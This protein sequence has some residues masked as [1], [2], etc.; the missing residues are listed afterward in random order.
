VLY[1]LGVVLG[2]GAMAWITHVAL[3]TERAEQ[4]ARRKATQVEKAR[5]ALWRMDS[6]MALFLAPEAAR[7]WSDFES[8]H[9]A[10]RA[11]T[12]TGG[13]GGADVLIPSPMLVADDPLVLLRF[14]IDAGGRFTSPLVPP[15]EFEAAARRVA[16]SPERR[17]VAEVR[18]KEIQGR[19]SLGSVRAAMVRHGAVLLSAGQMKELQDRTGQGGGAGGG[20]TIASPFR[21][22]QGAWTPF[23]DRDRLL[24]ARQVWVGDRELVQGCWLDWSA[25]KEVLMSTIRDILANADLL[26]A[27]PG[28]SPEAAG[29][30]SSLPVRLMPAGP[31]KAAPRLSSP[32]KAALI[33]GWTFTLLGA[34]AGGIVLVRATVQAE[35]RGAFASAVAHELRTP[36]TTFRLYT[37]LLAQGMVPAG[38]QQEMHE[39]LLSEADRL[40]HLVKNVLA[41]ARLESNRGVNLSDLSAGELLDRVGPRLAERARQSGMALERAE[42]EEL[43]GQVLRTDALVVEQIL[44]NLV[45]NACKYAAGAEDR[46]VRLELAREGSTLLLRVRDGGPGI[47]T[48]ERRRLFKPFQK[49]GPK[50]AR[51]APGV[52]LGLALCRRL[53][54]MLGGALDYEAA[55]RGACF[56]L[57]LPVRPG[58]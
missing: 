40:D 38:E 22:F 19:V 2:L 15:A 24:M 32:S 45:D 27:G 12:R 5:L 29:R 51:S 23:W 3:R 9:P 55:E 56:A 31:L 13:A 16:A 58:T 37:E 10:E 34:L 6:T 4:A 50:A 7:P 20:P 57:A 11:L 28:E 43:R 46:R 35:R 47:P 14:Q 25:L 30:L 17:R 42:S 48:H 26:P 18:L 54:S 52:G 36:L 49:L 44:Y 41:Y 1:V 39:T 8:F 33:T 21:V 53:A